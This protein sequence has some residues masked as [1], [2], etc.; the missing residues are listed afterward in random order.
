MTWLPLLFGALA[1][2]PTWGVVP[3]A[4]PEELREDVDTLRL[5]LVTDLEGRG[6]KVDREA[7]GRD[8][9]AEPACGAEAARALGVERV[10]AGSVGRFGEKLLVAAVSVAPDGTSESRRIV[11]D[12]VEDFDVAA[13]R[14]AA[15][16]LEGRPVEK[17]VQL[18]DVTALETERARRRRGTGGLTL[19][20]GAVIPIE[21]TYAGNAAGLAMQLGYWF[22]AKRF[23]IET[24][25]GFRFSTDPGGDRRFFDV[26]LSLGGYYI[27]GLG[28]FAPYFGGGVGLA[29]LYEARPGTI[30]VGDVIVTEHPGE[31]SDD[32]FAA[33]AYAR[34]GI[35]IL[36]TYRVRASVS[37]SYEAAFMDLNGRGYPQ[38]LLGMA[39]VHF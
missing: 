23:A 13:R 2:A 6:V 8:P 12:R 24:T 25:L 4:A 20:L 31:L 16:L 7:A 15:A 34:V 37:L 26:P 33:R 18:G 27:A 30:R 11:V 1:S 39:G 35:L 21:G 19:G 32:G 17:T 28:D 5:M 36:R 3:F 38:T 9:C 14:L 29:Y 22:E 10:V